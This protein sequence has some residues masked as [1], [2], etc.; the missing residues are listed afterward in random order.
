MQIHT[1]YQLFNIIQFHKPTLHMNN[2][3]DILIFI[4]NLLF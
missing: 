3:K 4:A 1:H 2:I